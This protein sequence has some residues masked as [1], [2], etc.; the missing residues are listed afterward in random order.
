MP[1]SLISIL[2]Y[3]CIKSIL[4][5]IFHQLNNMVLLESGSKC[6]MNNATILKLG[7]A[8]IKH[9]QKLFEFQICIKIFLASVVVAL[10]ALNAN[11]CNVRVGKISPTQFAA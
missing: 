2:R 10:L 1:F 5:G 11:F 3:L 6:I 8:N 7:E 4:I 9:F